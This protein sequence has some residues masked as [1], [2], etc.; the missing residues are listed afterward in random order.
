MQLDNKCQKPGIVFIH[1]FVVPDRERASPQ[2]SERVSM[3]HANKYQAIKLKHKKVAYN[4]IEYTHNNIEY[5]QERRESFSY[6]GPANLLCHPVKR[7]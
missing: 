1:E 5:T 4:N 7:P 6:N 3:L 2:A